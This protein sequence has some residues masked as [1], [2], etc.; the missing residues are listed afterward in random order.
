MIER[1]FA[2]VLEMSLSSA[3]VI[4][5]VCLIR[6][7]LRKAP[8]KYSYA[9][10]GLVLLRLLCPV[11][12]EVDFSPM[13]E[14]ITSGTV[15]QEFVSG[16]NTPVFTVQA[17]SVSTPQDPV[18]T[19]V[20]IGIQTPEIIGTPP[21]ASELTL[22][23]VLCLL[24]LVGMAAML[25]YSAVSLALLKRKLRVSMLLRENIYLADYIDSPFVIGLFRPRIY[26]PSSMG[27]DQAA[28]I[29]LHEQYHIRRF[30]PVVKLLFFGALCLHWFNPLVWLA[31]YLMSQDM[32][33]RC[34]EAVMKQMEGDIRLEYAASLLRLATGRRS[35]AATPLAFG[36]GDPKR[37][38]K[39]VLNYKKP[40]FWVTILAV[41]AVIVAAVCFLTN[42]KEDQPEL[43]EKDW[44]VSIGLTN[45]TK[46]YAVG[47]NVIQS[48]GLS[49]WPS[50][51]SRDY[52]SVSF[53]WE[54]LT[55][56]A[57]QETSVYSWDLS[58]SRMFTRPEFMELLQGEHFFLDEKEADDFLA[59]YP[60]E[61]IELRPFYKES[62]DESPSYC[63]ILFDE[64][65]V[66]FTTGALLRV[67]ELIPLDENGAEVQPVP[68]W[69]QLC[70][71]SAEDISWGQRTWY[72][73]SGEPQTERIDPGEYAGLVEALGGVAESDI[74][75]GALSESS[76]L[77][78]L[79][80]C[81]GIRYTMNLKE[82]GVEVQSGFEC[83]SI[84]SEELV[85]W[86]NSFQ[87]PRT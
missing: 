66:L 9:L 3:Y 2:A 68:R 35:F 70:G 74:K 14:K 48:V 43:P 34:D 6:L 49:Y 87:R 17:P 11:F 57:G 45:K 82:S 7:L 33:M 75:D 47:T 37:R 1:I 71:I 50:D 18:Q 55:V 24:W 69:Q 16:S 36:E 85:Q 25:I 59:R 73:V 4:L 13:P 31:F 60:G 61:R 22:R 79:I 38:I 58:R 52:G 62:A 39:N 86:M 83:W 5:G 56:T 10:W 20:S 27:Q 77:T 30:D 15:V 26:L 67:Y 72:T 32:E 44:N 84:Q 29:I 80:S 21:S 63:I 19:G 54:T 42:P 53:D 64:E 12:P 40:Q 8:R 28:H 41:I 78:V 81:G 76:S 46:T 65:P 51:G 23:Q